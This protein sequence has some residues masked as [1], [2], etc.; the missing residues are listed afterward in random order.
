MFSL[1]GSSVTFCWTLQT[2]FPRSSFLWVT[3]PQ[4]CQS[5]YKRCECHEGLA[6]TLQLLYLTCM[7][8]GEEGA[9]LSEATWQLLLLCFMVLIPG[10]QANHLNGFLMQWRNLKCTKAS[11]GEGNGTPLHYSC[12]ENPMEEGDW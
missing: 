9:A 8:L 3:L 12:L 10:A 1:M 5:L 2:F 11:L 4:L 6:A 7:V